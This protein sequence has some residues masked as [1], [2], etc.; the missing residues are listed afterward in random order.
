[1]E[2]VKEKLMKLIADI[3]KEEHILL[4]CIKDDAGEDVGFCCEN[5]RFSNNGCAD[6]VIAD[7]LIQNGVTIQE[8]VRTSKRKPT[9]EDADKLGC[10]LAYIDV[11]GIILTIPWYDVVPEIYSHWTATPQPPKG[12]Q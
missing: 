12:V 1:M 3:T 6:S 4:H 5:C 9:K 7:R 8:W 10:V 11:T 2:T